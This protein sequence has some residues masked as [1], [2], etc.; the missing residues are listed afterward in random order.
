MNYIMQMK[1][2][3]PTVKKKYEASVKMLTY[4]K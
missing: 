1:Q 4:Q 2:Y 3:N